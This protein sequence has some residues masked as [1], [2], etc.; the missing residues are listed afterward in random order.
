MD[1]LKK[2]L[3]FCFVGGVA[4]LIDYSVMNL[5]IAILGSSYLM[6][7]ISKI[8]GIIFSMMWN[9]PVNRHLT[10]KAHHGKVRKQLPKWLIVYAIT[11]L[12]NFLIFSLVIF[13]TGTELVPRT[14]AFIL[15]TCA[16]LILNFVFSLIWTFKDN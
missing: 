1:K 16:G 12:V 14:I 9:F 13:F 11:S 7:D 2:F 3:I 6:T 4:T 15:G 5:S 10:F 8:L